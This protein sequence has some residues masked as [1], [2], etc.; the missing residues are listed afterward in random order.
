[1]EK[2]AQRALELNINS[3]TNAFSV[4][5]SQLF[6][7]IAEHV[8]LETV[9]NHELKE[10]FSIVRKQLS[11]LNWQEMVTHAI[12]HLPFGLNQTGIAWEGSYPCTGCPDAMIERGHCYH[13]GE[14]KAWDIFEAKL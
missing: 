2:I 12:N 11:H 13:E 10:I 5:D 1:M 3:E 6:H 14:C 4:T 7:E 8:D 9:S